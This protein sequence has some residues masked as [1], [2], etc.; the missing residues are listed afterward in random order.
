MTCRPNVVRQQ[1]GHLRQR[2]P[3]LPCAAPRPARP[4]RDRAAPPPRPARRRSAARGGP[5]PAADTASS[6]RPRCRSAARP[7]APRAALPDT[8]TPRGSLRPRRRSPDTPAGTGAAWVS[9]TR[10]GRGTAAV[11]AILR[12]GPPAGMRP[13]RPCGRSLANGAAWRWPARRAAA[14]CGYHGRKIRCCRTVVSDDAS[15]R[16]GAAGGR[17]GI[18]GLVQVA[19]GQVNSPEA[20]LQVGAQN[21]QGEAASA[22]RHATQC[23]DQVLD[24]P[25][26]CSQTSDPRRNQVCESD[27]MASPARFCGCLQLNLFERRPLSGVAGK[28]KRASPPEFG[29]S[30]E[31]D[32][33]VHSGLVR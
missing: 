15:R 19:L 11:A 6:G 5:A 26:L 22:E 12:A 1:V 9:S 17:S 25:N 16:S 18:A 33:E 2:H 10:A 20:V 24:F 27:C 3:H 21:L 30:L 13:P 23:H 32:D 28:R 8:A 14:N 4:P 31:L 29:S 7:G